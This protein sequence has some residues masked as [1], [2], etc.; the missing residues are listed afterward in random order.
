MPG[1][2]WAWLTCG[3][4]H[5]SCA[6]GEDRCAW[7]SGAASTAKCVLTKRGRWEQD[8]CLPELIELFAETTC[9]AALVDWDGAVGARCDGGVKKVYDRDDPLVSPINLPLAGLPPMLVQ[10]IAVCG[11]PSPI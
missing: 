6:G 10:V 2:P 7:A 1:T 3:I 4:A 11:I 5:N 8:Y 9:T